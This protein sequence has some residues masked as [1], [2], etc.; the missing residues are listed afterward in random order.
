MGQDVVGKA[1]GRVDVRRSPLPAPDDR[2]PHHASRREVGEL[3]VGAQLDEGGE[4]RGLSTGA[5]L[6]HR[7]A[8]RAQQ[9]REEREAARHGGGREI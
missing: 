7:S 6:E 5:H 2:P 8:T 4:A 1:D 3:D 9:R